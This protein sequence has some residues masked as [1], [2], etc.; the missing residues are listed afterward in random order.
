MTGLRVAFAR[1][2]CCC[3]SGI[4]VGPR[5]GEPTPERAGLDGID[6]VESFARDRLFCD[7]NLLLLVTFAGPPRRPGAGNPAPSLMYFV[8]SKVSLNIVISLAVTTYVFSCFFAFSEAK[9]LWS[10]ARAA[11]VPAVIEAILE[12]EA[13]AE[14]LAVL[15]VDFVK[16]GTLSFFGANM[17]RNLA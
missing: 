15:G 5:E 10:W 1:S 11:S 2:A 8:L 7:R 12:L 14:L 17:A 9:E 4:D 16:A 13:E 3:D 6:L